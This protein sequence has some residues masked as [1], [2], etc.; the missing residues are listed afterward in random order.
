MT[1]TSQAT[2][3]VTGAAA[4]VMAHRQSFVAEDVKKYIIS[5]GDQEASLIQKTGTSRKLNLFKALAIFD[6][7]EGLTGVLAANTSEMKDRFTLDPTA[8]HKVGSESSTNRIS[9]FGRDMM[10]ALNKVD[11]PKKN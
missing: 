6:Q 9:Q 1:G 8:Q 11:V 2:A 4:V 5:T 3:F 7:S 10:N